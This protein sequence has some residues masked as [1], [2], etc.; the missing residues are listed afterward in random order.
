MIKYYPLSKIFHKDDTEVFKKE[1][2]KRINQFSAYK[3]GI[4]IK[5]FKNERFFEEKV[6][7]FLVNIPYLAK[8]N[9]E[10][11]E[12]SKQITLLQSELPDVSKDDFFT[13]LLVNEIQS[14]N[15]VENVRSTKKE[16][17]DVLEGI[18]HN[19][20][21]QKD[22]PNIKKRFLGL[23]KLYYYLDKKN[24]IES[25]ID[26]KNIYNEL[27]ES[28]IEQ[29][30]ILDGNLFRKY[31]VSVNNGIKDVHQGV[32]PESEIIKK[33]T[34]LII[35]LN[36]K[37][38]PTL[39]KLMVGH[40]IFEYIHP[41]YD[42]N[43]RTGRYIVCKGLSQ[44]LDRY[45]AVTFS[46]IINRHKDKYYKAFTNTSDPFNKGEA[47][48]FVIDMLEMIKEGQEQ[49]LDNLKENLEKLKNI[50]KNIEKYIETDF[51][52]QV[53]FILAQ[54]AIFQPP[55]FRIQ[56]NDLADYLNCGR[57]RIMN[58]IKNYEDK[59][60]YIKKRPTII[61]L[62]DEFMDSLKTR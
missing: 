27:V 39:Y 45:S 15:E 17:S 2:K 38:M 23:V 51:E 54:S 4:T 14:T 16:I 34:E 55:Q 8:L 59:I 6:E 57:R 53:F 56:V 25:I 58:A 37:E 35:F 21:E 22:N 10:I 36:K 26:I 52:R 49:V 50:E 41:F 29:D 46:Y 30:N 48:F 3:T 47:T 32:S 33:L 7:V 62:K 19:L 60:D 40:Y 5:P 44:K 11:I 28:E 20:D 61:T 9:E 43:G 18:K 42:G 13:K 24:D 31:S 12:N 1:Y